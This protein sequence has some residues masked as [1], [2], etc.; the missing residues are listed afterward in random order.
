MLAWGAV[1]CWAVFIFFMSAHTGTD[2][3]GE[4]LV[5]QVKRWLVSLASPVFGPETDVVSVAGHFCEYVVFGVLLLVALHV[6]R[7]A[8]R[9][10]VLVLGAIALASAYGVTD[11]FHQLFV[12]GRFCD[13]ADWLTDTLGAT[14]GAV[15]A[16]LASRLAGVHNGSHAD[17][18]VSS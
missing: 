5:A 12:P 7:P 9:W 3:D 4:G 10:G 13:P 17:A 1:G 6:T 18:P 11:E 2:F 8:A 16:M 15:G 14:V